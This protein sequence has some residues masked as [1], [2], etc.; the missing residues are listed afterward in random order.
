ML[1][2]FSVWKQLVKMSISKQIIE[3]SHACLLGAMLFGDSG[4]QLI[5][6]GPLNSKLRR[7]SSF[8]SHQGIKCH[9]YLVWRK[10]AISIEMIEVSLTN[11]HTGLH[12]FNLPSCFHE[13]IWVLI[14][15]IC[16]LQKHLKNMM[17]SSFLMYVCSK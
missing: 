4:K 7:K 14:L 1:K 6:L 2:C 16:K 3:W 5:W 12:I 9:S 8:F 10:I 13:V 11:I 15:R 17:L